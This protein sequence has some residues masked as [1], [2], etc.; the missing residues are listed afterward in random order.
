MLYPAELQALLLQ[1]TIAQH[2]TLCP[3]ARSTR[4]R[5][6]KVFRS[7]V[8]LT[9]FVEMHGPSYLFQDRFIRRRFSDPVTHTLLSDCIQELVRSGSAQDDDGDQ[10]I[11]RTKVRDDGRSVH[12]G[13]FQVAQNR[14]DARGKAFLFHEI[15]GVLPALG[16]QG[17]VTGFPQHQLQRVSNVLIIID[18]EN[19]MHESYSG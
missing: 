14:G 5:S 19:A 6:G 4:L 8:S 18:N 10:R 16:Q 12:A 17:A 1:G 11:M 9:Y 2:F 7:P 3:P 15:D 13:H